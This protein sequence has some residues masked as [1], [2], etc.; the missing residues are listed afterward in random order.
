MLDEN[1]NAVLFKL[2]SV[3]FFQ[4]MCIF[5]K[6]FSRKNKR[7]ALP[8]KVLIMLPSCSIISNI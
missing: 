3:N 4:S 7:I 5:K 8:S 6:D 2:L 1:N